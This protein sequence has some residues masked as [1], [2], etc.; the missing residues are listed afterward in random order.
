VPTLLVIAFL[1]IVLRPNVHDRN[2]KAHEQDTNVL[3]HKYDVRQAL[4][5]LVGFH[6]YVAVTVKECED[7]CPDNGEVECDDD[8]D[9]PERQEPRSCQGDAYTVEQRHRDDLGG[10][11]IPVI[12]REGTEVLCSPQENCLAC[13]SGRKRNARLVINPAN[14]RLIYSVHLQVERVYT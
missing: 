13:V 14:M 3:G 5:N 2:K 6:E 7:N 10:R 11:L 9:G 4:R 8:D 1:H 12:A